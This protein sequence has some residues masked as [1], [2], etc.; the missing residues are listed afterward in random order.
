M[1]SCT[2]VYPHE[3]CGSLEVFFFGFLCRDKNIL[4][5]HGHQQWLIAKSDCSFSL[6][7]CWFHHLNCWIFLKLWCWFNSYV[8]FEVSLCNLE[9]ICF[10]NA[11]IGIT[12][13]ELLL[14][15]KINRL[16][17]SEVFWQLWTCY[18]HVTALIIK[19]NSFSM[20]YT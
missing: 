4:K 6:S 1:K 20:I 17:T 12:R 18:I 11:N 15:W 7:F 5:G 2:L 19:L 13:R 8:Q 16:S 10:M 14:G 9:F 3:L